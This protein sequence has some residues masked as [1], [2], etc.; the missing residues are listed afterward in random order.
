MAFNEGDKFELK[1][2]M[3]HVERWFD[4]QQPHSE[5]SVYIATDDPAV[6]AEARTK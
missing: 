4:S 6:I 2:Y 3:D 5:R 1:E